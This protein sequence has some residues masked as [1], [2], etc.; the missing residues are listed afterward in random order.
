MNEEQ[1]MAMDNISSSFSKQE[2]NEEALELSKRSNSIWVELL[3]KTTIYAQLL[4]NNVNQK[5]ALYQKL[6]MLPESFHEMNKLS[7]HLQ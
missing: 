3:K 1:A 6:D 7:F 5:A 2:R 4:I